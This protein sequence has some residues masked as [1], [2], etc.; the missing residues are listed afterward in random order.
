MWQDIAPYG[1]AFLAGLALGV[2]YFGGLWITVQR[3][4]TARRPA[5]LSLASM[6]V[7]MAVTL[8]GFYLVMAGQWQRLLVCVAG[9]FIARI[10]LVRRWKPA[11]PAASSK[12]HSIQEGTRHADQS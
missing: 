1:L 2:F 10:F 8:G 6:A 11:S 7:R 4:P 12:R 3:L 5:L 9:F